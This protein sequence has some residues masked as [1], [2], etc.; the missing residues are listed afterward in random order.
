MP[1]GG[2]TRR[3]SRQPTRFAVCPR[4]SMVVGRH[5]EQEELMRRPSAT[6]SAWT[7]VQR[8]GARSDREDPRRVIPPPRHP[9]AQ[10]DVR[11]SR[12][13]RHQGAGD[14]ASGREANARTR[15]ADQRVAFGGHRAGRRHE[16]GVVRICPPALDGSILRPRRPWHSIPAFRRRPIPAGS[17][18]RGI[19]VRREKEPPCSPFAVSK[20]DTARSRSCAGLT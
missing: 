6:E 13:R 4:L 10:L 20:P 8:G 1:E 5:Q 18:P 2:L 17:S 9:R 16:I 15:D 12:T 3:S 14:R 11:L 7:S 19:L